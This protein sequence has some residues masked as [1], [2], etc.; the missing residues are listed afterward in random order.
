MRQ[1]NTKT[2][3]PERQPIYIGQ[4]NF[5]HKFIFKFMCFVKIHVNIITQNISANFEGD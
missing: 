3:Q 2:A 5:F 4:V 1:N